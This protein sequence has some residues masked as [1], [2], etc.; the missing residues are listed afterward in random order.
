MHLGWG[1]RFNGVF[2]GSANAPVLSC[3][4]CH[5]ASQ[6]PTLSAVSPRVNVPPIPVPKVGSLASEEWMWWFQDI[7]PGKTLNK[8]TVSFDTDMLLLKGIYAYLAS[9]SQREKGKF[10]VLERSKLFN[11]LSE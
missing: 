7:K 9:E 6:F 3:G 2:N 1:G 5:T 4:S 10:A 11:N 8:G